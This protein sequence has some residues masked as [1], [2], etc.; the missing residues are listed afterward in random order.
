AIR[1]AY[2]DLPLCYTRFHM[3]PSFPAAQADVLAL[4]GPPSDPA[5]LARRAALVDQAEAFLLEARA[6]NTRRAYGS[7]WRHFERWCRE[8]AVAAC[9]A[10]PE[11]VA[12]YLTALSAT[13]KVSTLTRR[14]SAIADAH[15]TAGVS[16]PGEDAGVR[17]LMAGIRRSL[18]TA[19]LAKRPVLVG[20]LLALLAAVPDNL[21]CLRDRALL[22]LGFSGAFRRSEL[23]ALDRE[24]LSPTGDGLVVTLRRSKT[25]QEAAGRKVA[26]PRGREAG[27]CP[28][29][30]LARWT[31]AAGIEAGP[32][33]LRVNR[34][35]QLLPHR[36]SGE[37][38]ALVVKRRAA[39]AGYA[40]EEFAGHSLRAGLATAAA[41]AGKSERAIMNQT[42][43]KS[44]A[45]LRR[46]IR[47]AN[48][49]RD[50]AAEGLGL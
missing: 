37:A 18:G 44:T 4:P 26:I 2:R 33:F 29:E 8:R 3:E 50:N 23:V 12:L 20:D 1:E 40:P 42:G 9:P 5:A 49:F 47:D 13:H 16:S 27:T 25:D 35:G 21:L 22:L 15:R 11:T 32:L 34:H 46:Y 10:G 30:A 45:T 24:D 14:L 6:A 48:L 17:R 43:H 19:A 31:A 38:V 36:L 39:A 28:V 41:I 7:D